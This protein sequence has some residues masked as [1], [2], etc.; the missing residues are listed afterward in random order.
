MQQ[1]AHDER[2]LAM[3]TAMSGEERAQELFDEFSSW[4]EEFSLLF[5]RFV[6]GGLYSRTVLDQKTRELCAISALVARNALP[7]LGS[8]MK[9]ALRMGATR[10]E[11]ME[12][13]F[14][15][16]V[17]AGAPNTLQ[18]ARLATSIFKEMD[19]KEKDRSL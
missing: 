11:V 16:C 15:T 13:C 5:Q 18:A 14:Q 9:A 12:V 7:Q 8:H 4:D 2:A 1:P 6:F 3:S 10:A 17:Y 19:E